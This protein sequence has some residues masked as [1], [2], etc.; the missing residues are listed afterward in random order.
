[1]GSWGPGVAEND[2]AQDLLS[3]E[4]RE[5]VREGVGRFAPRCVP[6][7]VSD[8]SRRPAAPPLGPG[9]PAEAWIATNGG[10]SLF[11]G[12]PEP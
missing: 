7:E 3:V 12:E 8:A 4:T 5:G 1:M 10:L 9:S 6:G 2:H 11:V